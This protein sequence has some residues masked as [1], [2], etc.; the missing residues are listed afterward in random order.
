[1]S[2]YEYIMKSIDFVENNLIHDLSLENCS[3]SAGYS[4]YYYHKIF[5][6]TVGLTLGEYIRKRRLTK[7]SKMLLESSLSVFQVAINCGY[8]STENFVRSFKKEHGISPLEH[9][10]L[11]NSLHL[12][13]PYK[14]TDQKDVMIIPDLVE[15][16]PIPLRCNRYKMNSENR[17]CVIPRAWNRYHKSMKFN[18]DV[19]SY[20]YGWL[21]VHDDL[22]YYW[23][24]TE[25]GDGE[26]IMTIPKGLYLKFETPK[27]DAFTFVETIHE[28]LDNVYKYLEENN[29][30]QNGSYA[31]ERYIES[32][33]TF[34]EEIF[35]SVKEVK[36]DE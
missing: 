6:S 36:F 25:S 18:D 7:A 3:R 2:Y 8:N 21:E 26:Y 12:L 34:S 22:L 32:S 35:I 16:S 33:R 14:R 1:M 23:I 10:K 29:I 13:E 28:T 9:R 17:H 20:D 27:A 19:S 30:R 15:L 24:G 11:R 31:F 4:E 5:K